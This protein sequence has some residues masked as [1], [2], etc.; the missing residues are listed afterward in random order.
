MDDSQWMFSEEGDW[1]EG[2]EERWSSPEE[3]L[4]NLNCE[5]RYRLCKAWLYLF[6]FKPSDPPPLSPMQMEMVGASCHPT[7]FWNSHFFLL[8]LFCS[9]I[10]ISSF[11]HLAI[12][13]SN[14]F[15]PPHL[16]S[17]PMVCCPLHSILLLSLWTFFLFCFFLLLS[18]YSTYCLSIP[19]SQSCVCSAVDSLYP[20]IRVPLLLISFIA[21]AS[22]SLTFPSPHFMKHMALPI[23]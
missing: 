16:L 4:H 1:V 12:L 13:C 15:S 14:F 23:A 9:I 21:L 7:A 19:L 2:L 5:D 20:S 8:S 18:F 3:W 17:W 6:S 11:Y 22:Y 10:F